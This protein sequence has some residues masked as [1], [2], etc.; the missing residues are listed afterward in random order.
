MARLPTWAIIVIT[1]VLL[2]GGLEAASF[3]KPTQT[4]ADI[5]K[6][7]VFGQVSIVQFLCVGILVEILE[8]LFWTVAFVELGAKL[9]KSPLLGAVLGVIAYSIL[10]H[11][12]GGISAIL[13]SGWIVLVLNASYVVLRQRS[14]LVAIFST[15]A[16]KIAF[17]TLGAISIYPS[18]A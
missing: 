17:I 5:E 4:N 16:Q 10:F 2:F 9:A 15:V 18:G 1:S 8:A 7:R 3:L 13:I 14:Q 12:S 11:W 6:L